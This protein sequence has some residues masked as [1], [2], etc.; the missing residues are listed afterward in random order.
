MGASSQEEGQAMSTSPGLSPEAEMRLDSLASQTGRSRE[1]YLPEIIERGLE[2][3]ED[4]YLAVE[5]RERVRAGKERVYSD[6]ELSERLG[7]E[8]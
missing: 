5:V 2:E 3:V 7:L 1:Y 4:Y 8:D 6:A